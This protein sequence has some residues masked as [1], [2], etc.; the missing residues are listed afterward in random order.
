MRPKPI[1]IAVLAVLGVVVA[2]GITGV[3][4]AVVS[5]PIGLNGSPD[6]LG[7]SLTPV[8]GSTTRTVTVKRTVTVDSKPATGTTSGPVADPSSSVGRPGSGSGRSAPSATP[9]PQSGSGEREG[10]RPTQADPGGES[11]EPPGH[12]DYD[13]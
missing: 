2:A 3:A 12:W 5:R 10:R 11:A 9:S 13:D 8:G 7:R 1:L 6:D 4:S